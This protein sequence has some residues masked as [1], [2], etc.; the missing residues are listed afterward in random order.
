M[1]LCVHVRCINQSLHI[2]LSSEAPKPEQSD[3]N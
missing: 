1:P 3:L 2:G